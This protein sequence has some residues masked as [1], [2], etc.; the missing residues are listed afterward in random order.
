MHEFLDALRKGKTDAA[1]SHLTPVAL[2]LLQQS[3]SCIVMPASETAQFRVGK[4][5]KHDSERA[6]VDAV[7]SDLDVDGNRVDEVMLWA[8]R[9]VEGRWRVS[10]MVADPNGENPVICDFENPA[11]YGQPTQTGAP[12]ISRQ[13]K[14]EAADPFQ[15]GV[16]R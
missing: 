3:D 2:E 5:E 14:Q 12:D 7:W 9:L 11:E 10:G 13:A 6:T 15:Q 4:V 1:N 16:V 8:L